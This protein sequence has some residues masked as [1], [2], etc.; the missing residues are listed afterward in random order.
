MVSEGSKARKTRGQEGAR[1]ERPYPVKKQAKAMEDRSPGR[2]S[3]VQIVSFP[4]IHATYNSGS[5]DNDSVALELQG[6]RV[7]Q[8]PAQQ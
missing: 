4:L 2:P 1:F 8:L 6:L 7:T 5:G 3:P